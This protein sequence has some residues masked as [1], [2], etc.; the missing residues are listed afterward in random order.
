ML[1]SSFQRAKPILIAL[2][3][4]VALAL[5]LV[6]V[7]RVS[8]L[9]AHLPAPERYGDPFEVL[10]LIDRF[11]NALLQGG[12]PQFVPEVWHPAGLTIG[13]L[14]YTPATF[15]IMM[16]FRAVGNAIFAYNVSTLLGV[17][18]CFA[19]M[20][21]LARR[22][23]GVFAST[24]A[25]LLFTFAPFM[26]ERIINGH[27]NILWAMAILPY[28]M[29]ALLKFI[30]AGD[31]RS[32]IPM[33]VWS[34]VAWGALIH[35]QLY[36]VWWGALLWLCIAVIAWRQKR[37]LVSLIIPIVAVLVASPSLLY[38]AL[39]STQAQVVTDALPAL[40]GWGASLNSL[41][42][43]S[44]FHPIAPIQAFATWAYSGI[45]NESGIANWGLALSIVGVAG[46]VIALR[47]LNGERI[48]E[49][50]WLIAVAA[51][52]FV[53]ALGLAVK[54]NGQP[55][56]APIF[57]PLNR[58]I[59]SIGHA[60][61]PELFV[62]AEPI[63]E[64]ANAIPTPAT[65]LAA[66]MPRWDTARV[67][68]RF[69]FLGGVVLALLA[70]LVLMRLRWP[71]RIA[72]AAVLLIEVLPA[73]TSDL[74]VPALAHPAYDWIEQQQGRPANG[75]WQWNI[76]N[77]SDAPDIVPILLGGKV[78]FSARM[79]NFAVASGFGSY[80]AKQIYEFRAH[81]VQT[82][83][84]P[85][86][87]RTP[88]YLRAMRV[89]YVLVHRIFNRDTRVWDELR[90][91][92][93]FKPAGCFQ[94]FTENS[95]WPHEICIAE[96]I[97][98]DDDPINIIPSY[99]WSPETWGV[100]AMATRASGNFITSRAGEHH[101]RLRAFPSCVEGQSQTLRVRVNGALAGE[102]AWSNCDEAAL[103]VVLPANIVKQ[104]WNDIAFEFA[105]THA[106]AGD[107]RSLA[108]GFSQL[109]VDP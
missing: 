10:W 36:G 82:E 56:Q 105:Y 103:D 52:S 27:A 44:I 15:L 51:V 19:G 102:H 69:S 61:K 32:A 101:L 79:H 85:S 70:A 73:P 90:R 46:A 48:D 30:A 35:F 49:W 54:W 38:Y 60:L 39:S 91:S 95:M 40:V 42:I 64:L 87:M 14:G 106:P 93:Y 104:G 89:R 33:A 12:L 97:W 50:R 107:T 8:D 78:I 9:F 62:T 2:F 108:V 11:Y 31:R 3:P 45:A 37:L 75:D 26:N 6:W 88:F 43:P 25:A 58:L 86:D 68:A 5:M 28:L 100:W 109:R 74:P 99:D 34:G 7:W 1:T 22:Y 76:L 29:L 83:N 81:M 94:P 63:K 16:P 18:V 71:A 20:F 84:W 21:V 41:P 17:A 4:A 80:P 23:A 67:Y 92:P 47:K 53:L 66:I 57:A 65:M 24:V 59:W 96:T 77:L 72:L 13:A 98:R 55:I